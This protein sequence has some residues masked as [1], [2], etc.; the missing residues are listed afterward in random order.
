MNKTAKKIIIGLLIAASIAMMVWFFVVKP[1]KDAEADLEDITG[2]TK[3][4]TTGG[5]TSIAPPKADKY[6]YDLVTVF[7]N[8]HPITQWMKGKQVAQLQVYLGYKG[9][10]VDGKWGP[11]TQEDF[12]AKQFPIANQPGK[13]YSVLTKSLYDKLALSHYNVDHVKIS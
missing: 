3:A 4:P 8:D 7:D 12:M 6:N 5:T 1:K 9:S 2:G 10:D 11:K 13:V